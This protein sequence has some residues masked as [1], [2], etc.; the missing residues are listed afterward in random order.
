[1]SL[2]LINLPVLGLGIFD[3]FVLVLLA[4]V[5]LSFLT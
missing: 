3:H 5:V 4:F 2:I 1:L